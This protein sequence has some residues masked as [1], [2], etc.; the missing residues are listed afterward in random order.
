LAL[1]TATIWEVRAAGSDSAAGGG[2]NPSNANFP[3]DGTVDTN[4]GN[5]SAPVFSSA[6]YNFTANDVG[7]WLFVKSGTN[8]YP[9]WYQIA[10]VASNKATLSAAI[11]AGIRH[12]SNVASYASLN[13]GIAS[14][15]TPSSI[16]WG[17]DYSQ[18][19][20]RRIAFTDM[21][22]GGTT[23]QFT[24]AANPVG[25][26]FVG[27]IIRVTSGTGFTQQYVEVVSTSGTT[28]T[29]DKSLG[30]GGSTGG[31]GSL[32]G[33]F[34]TLSPFTT[35]APEYT[36]GWVVF[37]GEG[38][39]SHTVQ[40]SFRTTIKI[41]GYGTNRMTRPT[42]RP[43]LRST[44]AGA[45]F[46]VDGASP[47]VVAVFNLDFDGQNSN[48]TYA[49]ELIS[50]TAAFVWYVENCIARRMITAGL[51]SPS[52]GQVSQLINSLVHSN[53]VGLAN[54]QCQ[55]YII[56]S[57]IRDHTSYGVGGNSSNHSVIAKNCIIARN[58]IGINAYSVDVER[59]TIHSNTSHGIASSLAG[60][61]Q[62]GSTLRNTILYGNGGYG[63]RTGG[64]LSGFNVTGLTPYQASTFSF[65][66]IAAGSNT[67]GNYEGIDVNP[68]GHVT[69][70]GDP[71]T[72]A[73]NNDFSLDNT[74]SQ[75]A[76]CR[77]AGT[78]GLLPGGT[79]TGYPD[80]GAVQHQEAAGG[81]FLR[82]VGF[83]G[84]LL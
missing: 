12:V 4:T 57:I 79:T 13:T 60:T 10:S 27:N 39:Y 72:D 20:S 28:A 62:G 70:S 61:L 23:T 58:S 5:T 64:F 54:V 59:C 77:G 16:T 17:I 74:A 56:N 49:F 76:S 7:A 21:V 41:I 63:I 66:N 47:Y 80:I 42:T 22:I 19:D 43:I 6:S 82:P 44:F 35:T 18:M 69:L 55:T 2:F 71:C 11:G 38:T 65:R 24:S 75:G 50:G 15:G 83:G 73:T 9:G 48:V 3:T 25:K 81:G 78:P 53:P 33:A 31:N 52:S 34:A 46:G 32:G 68:E 26:N 40:P 84:G 1:S 14:V 29:C 51:A 45:L 67:S 36:A 37:I 8:T 30:T